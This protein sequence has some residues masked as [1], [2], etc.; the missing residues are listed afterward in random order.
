MNAAIFLDRD[1]VLIEDIHLL[2]KQGDIRDGV[3]MF[4]KG[5]K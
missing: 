3:V 2:I 1:G 5:K 4:S